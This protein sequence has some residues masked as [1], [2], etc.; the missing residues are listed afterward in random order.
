MASSRK[1]AHFGFSSDYPN[2]FVALVRLKYWLMGIWRYIRVQKPGTLLIGPQ[3]KPSTDLIE[4]DITYKCNLYCLN[5]N[6]SCTQAPANEHMPLSMVENFV[7]ESLTKKRQWQR[8]RVLGGEPTLHPQFHA[9]VETLLTYKNQVPH[10]KVEIVTNGYGVRVNRELAKLPPEVCVE[11]SAKISPIQPD[12][13]PFNLAPVDQPKYR[14]TD[15]TNGC[16]IMRDCGVGLTPRGYYPC[17]V[18]GG[19]DRVLGR[20]SGR[21]SLPD[22]NDNMCDLSREACRLC[23]RFEDGHY[24]PPKLR[25]KLAGEVL[26]PTWE[27][28]YREWKTSRQKT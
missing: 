16:A 1:K 2:R 4:I 12:F 24:V 25:K 13:G 20:T 5:C 14:F 11:N 18:A 22:P 15:F 3:Y 10:C 8:I 23:G 9:I 21:P 7:F 27:R 26:S 6:R 17:A 19:I 28:I